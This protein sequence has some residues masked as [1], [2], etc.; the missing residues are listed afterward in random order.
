MTDLN[1]Q[2]NPT[3]PPDDRPEGVP[4]HATWAN[5]LWYVG[6]VSIN[7]MAG[8]PTTPEAAASRRAEWQAQ[9][10]ALAAKQR[11]GLPPG[12]FRA[13]GL[14]YKG[15][16]Q[17]AVASKVAVE[18]EGGYSDDG[19]HQPGHAEHRAA[20]VA[21]IQKANAE[22]MQAIAE[23]ERATQARHEAAARRSQATDVLVDA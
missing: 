3:S 6:G 22:E 11:E 5:G 13:N 15:S 20:R 1:E 18:L 7:R 4:A 19:R 12:H 8:Q 14:I 9:Q 16:G 23:M 17:G 21:A 2:P 10:D